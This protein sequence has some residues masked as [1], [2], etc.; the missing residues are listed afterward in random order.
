M[1]EL[2]SQITG[3]FSKFLKEGR[4]IDGLNFGPRKTHMDF[5]SAI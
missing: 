4:G 2:Y 3:I 5:P 1:N